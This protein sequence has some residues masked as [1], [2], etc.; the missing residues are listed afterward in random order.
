MF[1]DPPAYMGD[2]NRPLPSWL[3]EADVRRYCAEVERLFNTVVFEADLKHAN[4]WR[5]RD[6][7]QVRDWFRR[8]RLDVRGH[9]LVWQNWKYLPE[10]DVAQLRAGAPEL[11]QTYLLEH[12][13]TATAAFKGMVYDWDVVN[14]P[15]ANHAW[16]DLLGYDAMAAWFAAARAADPDCRLTLCEGYGVTGSPPVQENLL[17]LVDE[18][19]QRSAPVTGLGIHGHIA[20]PGIPP[21]QVLASLD[22]LAAAGL[23]LQITE[24]D[25][26]CDDEELAADYVR[27]FLT[28]VFS[29]PAV[30]G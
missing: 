2:G 18:L 26:D 20:T 9:T 8:R 24:F 19:K 21:E 27:D 11:L 12:V 15:Y 3:P 7:L 29:H 14:E 13:R 25:F 17:R 16:T 5:H 30:D 22:R 6:A 28:V 10:K 23:P 1:K 4:W